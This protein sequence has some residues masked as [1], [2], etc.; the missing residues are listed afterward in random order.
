MEGGWI[1]VL[2]A[3]YW[4]IPL[5]KTVQRLGY[6]AFAID[7]NPDADGAAVADRF[8]AID[9][10]DA[11]GAITL[12]RELKILGAVTDQTDIPIPTL[13]KI[14][15]VLELSGPSPET[16]HNTTN[17][18]RMRLLAAE[19]GLQNPRY[20]VVTSVD[21]ALDAIDE[22]HPNAP[23]GVGLPCVVKPTDSQASRGV[24]L[25]EHRKDLRAAAE[26][27]F[28]FSREGRILVE[29]YLV[30]KE[31]TVEGCRY[32]DETHL[33]GV[34]T[35]S[36]TPP[37]HIIAMNLDFPAQLPDS[38]IEEIHRV[39]D[40]LVEALKIEAG[41]IHGELI[42]TDHGIYLVEMANRGGGSGTSSHCIPAISGVNLLEANVR[43]A[44]GDEQKIIR[45]KNRASVLRFLL[46]PPGKVER[47][48]GVEDASSLTGVV[49]FVM[50]IRPGDVLVPP[51]MDTQRHGCLITVGD[52]I[53][54]A[55]EV[56]DGVEEMVQ[57][58][59]DLS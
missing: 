9:I 1:L 48:E 34:S 14:C 30:G 19:A 24:Q 37:P 27:A 20:R 25:I 52:T 36:H 41:S 32:M 4:Q 16:A 53:D 50:Y 31:V 29:E 51:V 21:E 8:E 23:G 7:R 33:L 35:K 46:F 15:D 12:G 44:V 45:T 40:S 56:A 49:N 55:R 28:G 38:T 57:V 2:G 43:Y 17:K 13:A 42:V 5:I 6:R 47:I 10:T 3:G 54:K 22:D 18:A 58:R 59:Y 11:E 26:E 39:Y